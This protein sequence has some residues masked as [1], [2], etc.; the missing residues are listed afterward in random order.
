MST[1]LLHSPSGV[2]LNA[3]TAVNTFYS[4]V[5]NTQSVNSTINP[6][7]GV[8][9]EAYLQTATDRGMTVWP[10]TYAK[11]SADLAFKVCPDGITTDDVQW[12]KDMLK[13]VEASADKVVVF[14]GASVDVSLIGITY[15]REQ[16]PIAF[17][18]CIVQ[19]ISGQE[20]VTVDSGTVKTHAS[21][22]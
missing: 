4:S 15:G 22:T 3:L 8:A 14:P 5:I 11:A 19:V 20:I 16:V 1:G 7:K 2:T 13:Y 9:T 10:W 21:G 6:G 17:D 12:S 18:D